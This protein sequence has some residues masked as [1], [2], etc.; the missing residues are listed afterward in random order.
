MW[1]LSSFSSP[2][3]DECKQAKMTAYDNF[4]VAIKY[5]TFS[6]DLV[7]FNILDENFKFTPLTLTVIFDIIT[8][9]ILNIYNVKMFWGDLETLCFCL[10]TF[11]FGFQVS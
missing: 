5:T 4:N 11:S 8:Y 2:S 1:K 3:V 9:M 7:S 10:V 6:A